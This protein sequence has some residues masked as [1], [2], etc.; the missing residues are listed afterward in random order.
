M[1]KQE[2]D[3]VLHVFIVHS[4]CDGVIPVCYCTPLAKRLEK[5]I[6]R[7]RA[8]WNERLQQ[9]IDGLNLAASCGED[10]DFH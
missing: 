1:W 9:F 2:P 8:P 3:D 6:S 10:V 7:M 4:D 5:L